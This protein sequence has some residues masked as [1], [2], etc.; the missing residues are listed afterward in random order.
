[1]AAAASDDVAAKAEGII[2]HMNNDHKVSQTQ[3]L[4]T[5]EIHHVD[6]LTSPLFSMIALSTVCALYRTR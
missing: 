5:Y 3:Q 4:S 6:L 1:M 2:S